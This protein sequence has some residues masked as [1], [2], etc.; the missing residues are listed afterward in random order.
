MQQ[1]NGQPALGAI[2][3]NSAPRRARL[4]W[5]D[6]APTIRLLKEPTRRIRF[7]SQAQA[8]TLLSELPTHLLQMATFAL[9]TG[10]RAANVTGL[11]WDQ[12][13]LSRRLA[14]VHPDQA[15]A[16]KAIAVLDPRPSAY[17]GELAYPAGHAADRFAGAGRLGNRTHGAALRSFGGRSSGR[18]R[19]ERANPWHIPGTR[20]SGC[21]E[22]RTFNSWIY[23]WPGAESDNQHNVL[24]PMARGGWSC[25]KLPP[26]LPLTWQDGVCRSI[27]RKWLFKITPTPQIC[28]A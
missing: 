22:R 27:W 3:G 16:R 25:C 21:F 12:V 7:V 26:R 15:K 9:A 2:T 17:V 1:R 18:V 11:I 28:R 10:L 14:W 13:D 5:L 6:R 23:W 20:A 8:L 4:G 24:N 19:G